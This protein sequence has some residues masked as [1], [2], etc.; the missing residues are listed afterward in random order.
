MTDTDSST[1]VAVQADTLPSTREKPDGITAST[2]RNN[3]AD[4]ATPVN[5]E[6]LVYFKVSARPAIGDDYC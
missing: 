2:S 4:R 1:T 6:F 5:D 3:D